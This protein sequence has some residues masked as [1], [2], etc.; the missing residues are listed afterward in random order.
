V[1]ASAF[2]K[3]QGAGTYRRRVFPIDPLGVVFALAVV[4]VYELLR[5]RRRR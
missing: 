1:N 2:R 5:L 4:V 3:P